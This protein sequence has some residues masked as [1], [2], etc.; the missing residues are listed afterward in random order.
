MK[1][2]CKDIC[3]RKSKHHAGFQLVCL[4]LF[5]L[6]EGSEEKFTLVI[7]GCVEGRLCLPSTAWSAAHKKNYVFY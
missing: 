1:Q 7:V 6:E 5:S 4:L 3:G 2:V